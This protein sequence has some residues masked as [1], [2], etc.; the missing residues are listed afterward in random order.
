MIY[1]K[2]EFEEY[3]QFFVEQMKEMDSKRYII[4][5]S[6]IQKIIQT[7]ELLKKSLEGFEI[8]ITHEIGIPFLSMGSVTASATDLWTIDKKTLLDIIKASDAFEFYTRT[9]GKFVLELT[10]YHV[11]LR[12]N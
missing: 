2:D 11:V 6:V 7:K 5:P 4:N 10:F 8:Q 3:R 9:D 1:S 12:T